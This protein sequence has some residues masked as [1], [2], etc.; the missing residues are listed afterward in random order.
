[1]AKQK[2]SLKVSEI[3]RQQ[4][5]GGKLII[6]KQLNDGDN[7]SKFIISY[8]SDGL[9]IFALLTIPHQTVVASGLAKQ[10]QG[11][12]LII[13][14]RGFVEPKEYATDRQYMRYLDY[15]ARAGFAV[16]KSD[17]RGIGESE[18]EPASVLSSENAAD[19]L[20]GLASIQRNCH[21]HEGGNLWIP[22]RVGDDIKKGESY[23]LDF[24]R[25]GVWGHSMGGMISL[26]CML[27]N[28]LIKAGVIWAG[29]MIPYDQV[30]DRWLKSS[31][32]RQQDRAK[33]LLKTYGNPAKNPQAWHDI[34]PFYFLDKLSGPIQLHHG[35]KDHI[36]PVSDSQTFQEEL[37]KHHKDG[38]LYLY[39]NGGHNL[40][41]ENV[42]PQAMHN[43]VEFFKKQ[44]L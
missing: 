33:M 28:S 13:F 1:M 27:A 26:H 19:V 17:Y 23:L 9:K 43:T 41:E 21:S 7:Y 36:V 11:F 8:P 32:K 20:N 40:N 44:L 24:S 12:P 3:R 22:D 16:F 42:L 31:L 6:E 30:I 29:F 15:L 37:I 18:G 38:G 2:Y 39:E 4:Y 10:P 34:S 5:P 25:I 14:N 35:L